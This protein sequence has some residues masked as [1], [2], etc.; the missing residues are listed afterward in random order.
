VNRAQEA[1]PGVHGPGELERLRAPYL[2]DD[3]SI[4]PHREDEPLISLPEWPSVSYSS[5][6]S[7]WLA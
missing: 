4:R 2:T 1:A 5:D 6:M 3:D 7:R